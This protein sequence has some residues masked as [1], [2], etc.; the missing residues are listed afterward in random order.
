MPNLYII[1]A[2][3]EWETLVVLVIANNEVDAVNMAVEHCKKQDDDAQYISDPK[4]TYAYKLAEDKTIG[5]VKYWV[6]NG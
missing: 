3:H 6:H 1:D 4:V 2:C 5:V